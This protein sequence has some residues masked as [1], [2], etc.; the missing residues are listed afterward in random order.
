MLFRSLPAAGLLVLA[1]A[2]FSL[3]QQTIVFQKQPA[4]PG[5]MASQSLQCDLQLNMSI[6][7][8]GQIV[9]EQ[10]QGIVRSQ[11]RQ[12]TILQVE[13]DKPLK[14]EVRYLGSKVSVHTDG[15]AAQD[16]SQSIVGKTYMVTRDGENLTITYPDGAAPPADELEMV[17]SNMETFGLPNPIAE[18]F[19]GKKVRVGETLK[20]PAHL[21]QELLGFA[22][23][24]GGASGF[25]LKLQEVRPAAKKGLSPV[26]VFDIELQAD[27]PADASG[28]QMELAGQLEMEVATCRSRAV[29][30]KGPVVSEETHGPE[31]GQFQVRSEGQID[32]AVKA[33]YSASR[34]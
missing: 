17:M 7:Q 15:S 25:Q 4:R 16:I 12:L 20:L 19:H 33:E 11:Q 6:R 1:T 8:G 13:R 26:A 29:R 14:A 3:G 21:A 2:S 32:V 34:R 27:N 18:F 31:E 23:T 9:Q 5:E 24:P 22:E 10:K 28:V 30:L